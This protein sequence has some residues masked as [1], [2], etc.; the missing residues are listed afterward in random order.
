MGGSDA[1]CQTEGGTECTG[2]G[3]V[4]DKGPRTRVDGLVDALICA[5]TFAMVLTIRLLSLGL[6]SMPL[7]WP[8]SF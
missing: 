4:E 1:D 2:G 6:L 3:G 5:Q 8:S 7:N